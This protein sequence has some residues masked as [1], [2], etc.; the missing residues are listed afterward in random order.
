[1][2]AHLP[3]NAIEGRNKVSVASS[4]HEFRSSLVTVSCLIVRLRLKRNRHDCVEASRQS[5]CETSLADMID[6]A[7][8]FRARVS[9]LAAVS[10]RADRRCE[11]GDQ[12]R[13]GLQ[14]SMG[15]DHHLSQQ[16][17]DVNF[18]G[19]NADEDIIF[20]SHEP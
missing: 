4:P 19:L 16:R 6:P 11:L 13:G 7:Q 12:G 20:K 2:A 17:S 10:H 8:K 15:C 3:G 5:L 1:M 18:K 9:V 14:F